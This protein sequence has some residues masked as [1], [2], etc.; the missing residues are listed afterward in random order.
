[1]P[2]PGAII[3]ALSRGARPAAPREPAPALRLEPDFG[4]DP[5]EL[6]MWLHVPASA[7][8]A[9]PLVVVLHGCG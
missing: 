5:G 2:D 7:A 6:R 8:A 9:C 3:T 4:A 1:M